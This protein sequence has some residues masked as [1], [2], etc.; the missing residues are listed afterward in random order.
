MRRIKHHDILYTTVFLPESKTEFYI[1]RVIV[2]KLPSKEKRGCLV[3]ILEIG[4]TP[5]GS[6]KN[7]NRQKKLLQRKIS[8]EFK[9]LSF[10]LPPFMTPKVWLKGKFK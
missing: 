8:K 6:N 2:L 9:E 1:A 7:S 10:T 3:K 5:I 4:S